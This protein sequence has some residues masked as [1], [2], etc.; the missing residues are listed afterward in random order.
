MEGALEFARCRN[1]ISK[2]MTVSHPRLPDRTFGLIF[3]G[4][5]AIVA[6]VTWLVL[7]FFSVW[8]AIL[9]GLFLITALI[10][11][12]LLLPLNR[13]WLQLAKGLAQI[14]NFILLGL[15]FLLFVLPTSLIARLLGNDPLQRA[16]DRGRSS[17]WTPVQ[18]QVDPETLR[19]Q[20]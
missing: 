4:F 16:F 18:R 8:T 11:P 17:Y 13:L 19:D 1:F 7:G 12:I 10:C 2:G 6:A 3:A 5:F 20:F 15:F 9:A 14:N